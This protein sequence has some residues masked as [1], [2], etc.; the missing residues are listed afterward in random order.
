MCTFRPRTWFRQI[1]GAP[2]NRIRRKSGFSVHDHHIRSPSPCSLH[3]PTRLLPSPDPFCLYHCVDTHSSTNFVKFTSHP[4]SPL[5]RPQTLHQTT[6]RFFVTLLALAPLLALAAPLSINPPSARADVDGTTPRDWRRDT[7]TGDDSGVQAFPGHDWKRD[8]SAT[9]GFTSK[10]WK[11]DSAS[12]G[13]RSP[14]WKRGDAAA[15]GF[16]VRPYK[17]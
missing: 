14:T 6:M 17:Q 5:I 10:P 13:F 9:E 12:D 16:P 11:R 3:P 4:P 1:G 8:D 7:S 2:R 15:Q